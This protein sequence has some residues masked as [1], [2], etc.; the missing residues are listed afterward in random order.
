MAK[1]FSLLQVPLHLSEL[2]N[3]LEAKLNFF[4]LSGYCL[5]AMKYAKYRWARKEE[6]ARDWVKLVPDNRKVGRIKIM[7][8]R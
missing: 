4:L 8:G 3:K 2:A 6:A 7:Y 5:G 1:S